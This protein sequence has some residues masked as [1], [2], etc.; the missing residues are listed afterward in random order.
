MTAIRTSVGAAV[1]PR[2]VAIVLFACAIAAGL[3][4]VAAAF[5]SVVVTTGPQGSG[6]AAQLSAPTTQA[7]NATGSGA[8]AVSWAA[9][10]TQLTGAQYEVT[11]SSGPGSP[12]VV[13]T[14]SS[15]SC[16]DTGLTAGQTYGYSI[17]AALGAWRSSAAV[18]SAT[19]PV[20]TYAVALVAGP[21]T[22]GTPVT[23]ASV[24]AKL[25]A[26]TD[27]T[28]AGAKTVTWSGLANSPS[29]Q[30]PA[31]PSSAVTFVN[32][33]AAP[34]G[35]FTAYNAGSNTLT[36]TDSAVSGITGSATFS[37]DAATG[38]FVII[39]SGSP[40]ST[41]VTAAFAPMSVLV[42]DSYGN[43]V[44]GATVTFTAP[45]SG[46]SGTFA[47]GI[48]T[49]TTNASGAATAAT[50]TA[51]ATAGG[52]YNVTATS[53]IGA[54]SF[55]LTN[56][57]AP[58]VTT[59]ILATATRTQVG[60]S[61]TLL[62]SDG[63]GAITWS[64]SSGTLPAG[65]SLNAS[66][67]VI[68]GTVGAAANSATFTVVATDSKG[69]ASAGKSLTITVNA[70]PAVTT[71]TL[72]TA[73]QTQA[74]YSQPLA[75][76]G[77]TGAKTWA[78]TVGALPAG[79]SLN[80]STGVISGTV[81]AGATT[82]TFSVTV[83]DANSV[84]SPAASLTI[85]VNSPPSVTTTTLAAATRTQTGYSQTLASTGGTA[86]ITWSVT[87]GSLPTGLALNAST[88][89]IT[90]TVGAAANSATFT[91]V[92]TD[93]NNV[94]SA[95]K[96]LTITVNVPPSV[97]TT[98]LANATQG[99]AGYSQT[100]ASTGG[101]A[102]ITWAITV[103]TLPT[104]LSL[105]VST[106]VISGNVG[107][108]ATTQTFTVVATDANSVA[109]AGQ[110]LTITVTPNALTISS[111]SFNNGSGGTAGK[112]DNKTDTITVGFSAPVRPTSICSSFV[113]ATVISQVVGDGGATNGALTMTLK[114]NAAAPV[115]TNDQ[116]TITASSSACGG[117]VNIG[118]FDL[119]S[120]SWTTATLTYS[121]SGSNATS[122]T[123][124]GTHDTLTI[125][126]GNG[127][128]T[129]T[130]TVGSVTATYTPSSGIKDDATN[131]VSVTGT[132]TATGIQF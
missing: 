129:P 55:Q 130:G 64:I 125:R 67:G 14:V 63:T 50:F 35:S 65:L 4:G 131:L 123:L 25:G 85:S 54:A 116:I 115:T 12:T 3:C 98:T 43:L 76:T 68:S 73:T 15:T 72:A 20:P 90:G 58:V 19:T 1:K 47:G 57:A 107:A 113:N 70:A 78:V 51:N 104:G 22:A 128:S 69:V 66:T 40:Q 84:A 110:P 108:A 117:T 127:T 121:G 27:T 11:R 92:A 2:R 18:V 91:V 24:T 61:Q 38:S 124:N 30:V 111:L 52:A 32:G 81:G 97:T 42:K 6:R 45:V 122:L 41:T 99:Q 17:R 118:T 94:V 31:Y 119:G 49:A 82:Q 33:V 13:C 109:S 29:G 105:N 7:A 93:T 132:K 59:T 100:L 34:A 53:G 77:G 80:A 39:T 74:G 103:G 102:P 56:N 62:S 83:T 23:V 88:G 60:Y 37:V 87:V 79:L 46:A 75:S 126:V 114:D 26:T 9:P 112:I 89:A 8:V 5:W 120:P 10:G 106:G 86:P 21:Y 71:T 28:Y 48:N 44:S 96:S 36:A 95:G 101:T 16:N